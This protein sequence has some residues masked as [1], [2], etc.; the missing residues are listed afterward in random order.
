MIKRDGLGR[1]KK[2]IHPPTE[3]KKGS[4]PW[5]K[6]K[7]NRFLEKKCLTCG[8]TFRATKVQIKNGWGKYCSHK[9]KLPWNKGK[10]F[11]KIQKRTDGYLISNNGKTIHRLVV[12]KKIGR[13]LHTWEIVHHI[14]EIK[15][16]N[17]IE[18]LQIMSRNEHMILHRKLIKI[19]RGRKCA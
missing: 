6:G 1:Y 5:N 10:I 7:T 14:N 8:K 16:D 17:R 3:F 4:I 15:T 13:K 12:E 11:K 9:C 18:N 19:A 2:G